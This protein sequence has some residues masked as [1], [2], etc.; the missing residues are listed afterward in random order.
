MNTTYYPANIAHDWHEFMYGWMQEDDGEE[1]EVAGDGSI[2]P[3]S[4]TE[5]ASF[6]KRGPSKGPNRSWAWDVWICVLAMMAHTSSIGF[7][8]C[9]ARE[10]LDAVSRAAMLGVEADKAKAAC[11]FMLEWMRMDSQFVD[12]T[13][14]DAHAALMTTVNQGYR[15]SLSMLGLALKESPDTAPGSGKEEGE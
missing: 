8:T 4:S 6:V 15:R 11:K 1:E 3:E 5:D 2:S 13:L 10:R 12:K 7:A 9:L 14:V